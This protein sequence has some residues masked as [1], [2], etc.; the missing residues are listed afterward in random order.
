MNFR[1]EFAM[2]MVEIASFLHKF[3]LV[4][5]DDLM[6]IALRADVELERNR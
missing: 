1:V 3:G 4:S 5:D 6:G 2:M